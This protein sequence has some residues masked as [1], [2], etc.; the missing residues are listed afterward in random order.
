MKVLSKIPVN[1]LAD[2]GLLVERKPHVA[3]FWREATETDDMIG[4]VATFEGTLG[5]ASGMSVPNL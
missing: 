3:A 4:N 2:K 5:K 1:G